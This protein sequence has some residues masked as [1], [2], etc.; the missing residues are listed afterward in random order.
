MAQTLASVL[1]VEDDRTHRDFISQILE[2]MG[3]RVT[4]AHNGEEALAL[5]LN[6]KFDLV[7]M[8]VMMPRMGGIDAA[9]RLR[10]MI[11]HGDIKH[12]PVIAIT[13]THDETIQRECLEAGMVDVIS[14]EIW[15]PK[16]EPAIR[17]ALMKWIHPEAENSQFKGNA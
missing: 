16:W 3:C 8:D 1:L 9:R 4:V 11:R 12:V 2:N 17:D 10:D 13:A 6:R 7:L 14:K 5:A 15:K